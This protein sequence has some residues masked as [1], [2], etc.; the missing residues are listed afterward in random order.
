MRRKIASDANGLE[1]TTLSYSIYKFTALFDEPEGYASTAFGKIAEDWGYMLY[2][3]ATSFWET[4]AGSRDFDN[5]GS[6]CHGWSAVPSYFYQAYI[7]GV[8]P[9]K[10]GFELFQVKPLLPGIDR[11][12]GTVPTPHGNISVRVARKGDSIECEVSHPNQTS[13]RKVLP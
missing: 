8:K 13:C 7:L 5:S 3:R 10:P 9:L 2:N 4:I 6:T 1:K 12:S 11:A